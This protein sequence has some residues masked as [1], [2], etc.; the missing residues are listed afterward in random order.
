MGP[1]DFPG[2]SGA[3]L[4]KP[5]PTEA[6]IVAVPAITA[7]V[8]VGGGLRRAREPDSWARRREGPTCC[9][10][11]GKAT[12]A[13]EIHEVRATRM[14]PAPPRHA[15][16]SSEVT[17]PA[18]RADAGR[19]PSSLPWMRRAHCTREGLSNRLPGR[20]AR[21]P[22]GRAGSSCGA[23]SELARANDLAKGRQP[24]WRTQDGPRKFRLVAGVWPRSGTRGRLGYS[25]GRWE[26]GRGL[27]QPALRRATR[28]SRSEG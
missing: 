22:R 11:G 1:G 18:G 8:A 3:D 2:F 14:A 7:M 20:A 23:G 13:G 12:A 21:R 24:T 9:C 10:R 27:C 26:A 16:R 6:A 4:A 28:P 17:I 15:A 25:F 5:W 19:P